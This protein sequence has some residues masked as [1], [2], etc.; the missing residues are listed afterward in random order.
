MMQVVVVTG[1][2]GS[3]KSLACQILHDDYGWPVYEADHKVKELYLTHPSLLVDIEK[4]VGK[5]LRDQDGNFVPSMLAEV[6]FSDSSMLEAVEGLVFPA[7]MEDFERWKDINGRCGVVILESATILEKPSLK[8]IGDYILLIDAPLAVR[9]Q[10]AMQRDGVS[11]EKVS[12]RM[13][14]QTLMNDVSNGAIV[15]QVDDVIL[16]DGNTDLLRS[17][18][19]KFAEK[20]V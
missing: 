16:N 13:L 7:L 12:A 20:V 9:R 5:T 3:G 18:L 6:I 17:N 8:G 19:H 11:E 2:I 1:G 15:P 10:R 4:V 14:K